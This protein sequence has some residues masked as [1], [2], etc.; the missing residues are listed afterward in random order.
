MKP[1]VLLA[2]SQALV[3]EA[4]ARLLAPE[5]EVVGRA[6]D[7]LLLVEEALRLRPELVLMD[8]SL[9]RLGGL[10]AAGRLRAALPSTRVVLMAAPEDPQLAAEAF[11]A[12]VSGYLSRSA[13]ANELTLALRAV[14][15][16]ER[17]LPR[18]LAGGRPDALPAVRCLPGS[19]GR[20]SP[21]KREV[22]QLLAEGH[23]M[24]QAAAALGL[25][26]RTIA[27]HKYQ[28]MRELAVTSS[29]Q[30]VRV[31]VEGRLIGAPGN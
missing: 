23:S 5:F 3:L 6:A 10:L 31:A 27:F 24:K 9:P 25:S 1:S 22:V 29:A 18:S 14:L 19:L 7:G 4:F 26:T 28:A 2:D 11:L 17:W 16:G 21:R 30:L 8:L 12:G 20:L 13:T 15:R